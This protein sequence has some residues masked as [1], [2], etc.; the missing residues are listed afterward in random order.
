[1]P[2]PPNPTPLRPDL[3]PT[4]F[5]L[6]EAIR[7]MLARVESLWLDA[8]ISPS[9]G[10]VLE[11]L[12]IDF[13]GQARSGDLLGHPVRST[14]ALGKVLAG[15]ETK[16]MITRRRSAEDRRV[17]IVSATAEARELYDETIRRILTMVMAPTTADLG[18]AEFDA[19]REITSRLR[20]PDPGQ[21]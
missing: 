17:V 16:G 3:V 18:D 11:R 8:G 7:R 15:L 19:L 21:T 4:I 12:F 1:M 6:V 2:A 9:E 14:P 20:P 13:D 5:P 10:A